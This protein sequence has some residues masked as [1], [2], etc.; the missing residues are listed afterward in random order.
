MITAMPRI[1]IAVSDFADIVATFRDV[2][3][4]PVLDISDSSVESLGAHLGMCVPRGGSNIELMSPA[5]AD[6]PLSQS[7]QRFVDRR[8]AGLFALMLEAPD[9]D[10][11][12]ERLIAQGLNVLP[13]MA[14]AGGRDIHPSSTHGVLIRIYPVDSFQR[15]SPEPDNSLGLS[16]IM[17]VVI[18]VRD[19]DEAVHTYGDKLGLAVEPVKADRMRGVR[20]AVCRPPAGGVIELTSVDDASKPFAGELAQFIAR[21]GEGMH[22][23]ILQAAAFDQLAAALK[24]RGLQAVKVDTTIS[25]APEQTH[26]ARILIEASS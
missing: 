26:G 25:F 7:L 12:A 21:R 3:G 14:G 4:M 1:A 24:Q 10:E 18:A 9:P 20:S 19:I 6:A 17:R 15:H 16:G 2:F 22:S 13:L 5:V 23:L 8:G 11:E